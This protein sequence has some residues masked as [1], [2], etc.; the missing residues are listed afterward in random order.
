MITF[1]STR[2]FI[3]I[4]FCFGFIGTSAQSQTPN[5]KDKSPL[6]AGISAGIGSQGVSEFNGNRVK[7]HGSSDI[8]SSFHAN[9]VIGYQL[10]NK[11]SIYSGFSSKVLSAG[12]EFE[13]E[14]YSYNGSL[15][16]IP[17]TLR[18]THSNDRLT[19]FADLGLYYSFGNGDQPINETTTDQLSGQSF[20]NIGYQG[21]IGI[22]YNDTSGKWSYLINLGVMADS[23][24]K[25][26]ISLNGYS[27]NTGFLFYLF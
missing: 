11:L 20:N 19:P 24:K 16:Y 13:N 8:T 15:Y 25:G 4:L 21:A 14:K 5:T 26:K 12:F 17:L 22:M 18:W 9:I 6:I 7:D 23:S 3:A 10:S 2:F 1:T 27:I